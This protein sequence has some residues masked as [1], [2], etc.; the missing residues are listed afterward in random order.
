MIFVLFGVGKLNQ[1]GRRGRKKKEEKRNNKRERAFAAI[2][3]LLPACDLLRKL[4]FD[5]F[6]L[7]P[8]TYLRACFC[9]LQEACHGGWG[10]GVRLCGVSIH[11]SEASY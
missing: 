10:G 4:V 11:K 9:F 6:G 7:A 2:T 1:R 8:A 5:Y 3:Y